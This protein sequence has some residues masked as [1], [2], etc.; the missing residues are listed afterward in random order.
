MKKLVLSLT[1][2]PMLAQGQTLDDCQQAAEKNY[3]LIQQYGLIEDHPVDGCQHPEGVA[4]A[5]VGI[6]TSHVSE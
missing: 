3:P 4:T 2:L 5:S 6:G 1:M